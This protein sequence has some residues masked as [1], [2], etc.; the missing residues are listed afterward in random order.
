MILVNQHVTSFLLKPKIAEKEL[1]HI[2]NE[3]D[4]IIPTVLEIPSKEFPYEPKKVPF[5]TND[6]IQSC[7][8][9]I[10]C[11]MELISSKY[12]SFVC[13]LLFL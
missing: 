8:E 3:Y 11:F 5:K 7:R 2:I 6:R 12:S 13:I 1:R 4:G 10:N 9:L